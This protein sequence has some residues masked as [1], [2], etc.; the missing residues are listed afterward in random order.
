[1]FDDGA[2]PGL[3]LQNVTQIVLPG[4]VIVGD[5]DGDGRLETLRGAFTVWVRRKLISLG[6]GQVQDDPNVNTIILTAEG[7][8]PAEG[9]QFDSAVQGNRQFYANRATRVLEAEVAIGPPLGDVCNDTLPQA[10][11]TGMRCMP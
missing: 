4:N 9:A 8:A 7:V 10:S 3:P 5:L 6:A 11:E 1:M 2:T